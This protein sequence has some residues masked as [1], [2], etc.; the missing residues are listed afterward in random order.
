MHS[1]AER[2]AEV[3]GTARYDRAAAGTHL[4]VRLP[5]EPT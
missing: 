1:I 4:R 5:L 3:G 2:A